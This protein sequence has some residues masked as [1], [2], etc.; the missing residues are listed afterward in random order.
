MNWLVLVF[1]VSVLAL[2]YAALNFYSVKKVDEGT[3][4]MREIA[5]SIRELTK[6]RGEVTF[7]PSGALANDGKVIDDVRSYT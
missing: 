6:L 3:R 1:F 5:A 7:L 4:Q 2:A